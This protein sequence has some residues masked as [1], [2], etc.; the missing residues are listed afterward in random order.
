MGR[1]QIQ[2]M[3]EGAWLNTDDNMTLSTEH[4]KSSP[5][6]NIRNQCGDAIGARHPST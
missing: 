5:A 2:E 1:E 4:L 3:T 6:F